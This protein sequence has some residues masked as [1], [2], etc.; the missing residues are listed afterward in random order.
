MDRLGSR[1]LEAARGP[2]DL[3]AMDISEFYSLGG[4]FGFS[5]LKKDG[6]SPILGTSGFGVRHPE[7]WIT[8][9]EPL[10]CPYFLGVDPSY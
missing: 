8:S 10:L 3:A 5:S 6:L 4:L 1:F 9:K 7:N 2:E